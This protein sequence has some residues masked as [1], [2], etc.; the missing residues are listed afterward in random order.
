[1]QKRIMVV[2]D[3]PMIRQLV[4]IYL[5]KDGYEVHSAEDGLTAK[6]KFQQVAPCLVILDLMLP[7]INGLELC[8]IIR[9]D[10]NSDVPIIIVTAKIQEQDRIKGLKM[11]ADDYVIK[12]FSPEEL[13]ARVEAVLRRTTEHCHKMSFH[14]I[15]LKPKKQE[16]WKDGVQIE[17]TA[18][19]FALLK[20]FM[21]HP[22]L[23]QTRD[24]LLDQLYPL[25][26]KEVNERTI[27]VHIKNL[28]DKIEE[29]PSYPKWLVTVRGVGYKFVV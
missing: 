3:D 16:V 25:N 22:N 1:M 12:P 10:F 11:G 15:T 9:N 27:D 7:H 4:E 19:E 28:R 13:M 23:V 20:H 2:E 24:Q 6:E 14:G 5:R 18:S 26:E 17:L 29:N 21:S 8:S